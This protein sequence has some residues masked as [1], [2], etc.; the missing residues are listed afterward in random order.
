[1][2]IPTPPRPRVVLL[3]AAYP[4]LCRSQCGEDGRGH[5]AHWFDVGE[6][7]RS[8]PVGAADHRVCVKSCPKS[9]LLDVI[10]GDFDL[11]S[12]NTTT[13]KDSFVCYYKYQ[14]CL[15]EGTC[16]GEL[17][18]E[19]KYETQYADELVDSLAAPI[20]F[21]DISRWCQPVA[22]PTSSV[23]NRCWPDVRHTG[24][25]QALERLVKSTNGT[26]VYGAFDMVSDGFSDLYKAYAVW[27]V[28]GLA[29]PLVASFVWLVVM[30]YLSGVMAWLTVLVVNLV[31]IALTLWCFVKAGFIG[32]D[33]V[34]TIGYDLPDALDT[35]DEKNKE[36]FEYLS[37]TAAVVT[38]LMLLF[39]IIMIPRIRIA[40]ATIKVASQAIGAMPLIIFFPLV[41]FVFM[42][43]LVVYWA[44]ISALIYTAGEITLDDV[45]C[46]DLAFR[47]TAADECFGY[48]TSWDER[49]RYG[50][51][52]HLF[53]LL[54]TAQFIIGVA[55]TS[56][57]GAVASF[58][59]SRGDS[60][61]MP[62]SPV[63]SS[64]RRTCRYHLGSIAIGSFVVA[65]IQT[66]RI[67]LE[68]LDKKTK[69]AQA[70]NAP[71]RFLMCCAKYCLAYL[72]SVMK[73]IN[74]NGYIMIAVKGNNYCSSVSHAAGIIVRNAL[75]MVAVNT[76]G[77]AIPWLGKMLIS[78]GAGVL[79]FFACDLPE[80]SEGDSQV[81][82]PLFPVV[83]TVI[84]AY[85]VADCFFRC[86]SAL[87]LAGGC[88]FAHMSCPVRS[89]S[90]ARSLARSLACAD[91]RWPPR[92]ACTRW[93]WTPSF[94][95]TARIV[96]STTACHSTPRNSFW[97]PLGSARN[98]FASI[99]QRLRTR[100]PTRRNLRHRSLAQRKSSS[101]PVR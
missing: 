15:E 68:Y 88:A 30:R 59:W 52:Y 75:R 94:S 62:S 25:S 17:E 14:Y 29:I 12:L 79:A 77:D 93:R 45:Q 97:R 36:L 2:P 55:L 58:Y 8:G 56:I 84:F 13:I 19:E 39:T 85:F 47:A 23:L 33:A 72:E 65:V 83:A 48:S 73:F 35:A 99:R 51:L 95:R 18:G 3:T 46:A 60:A 71:L 50:F 69:E 63:L 9:G 26:F 98:N 81:S 42:V 5:S 86:A 89:S 11:S 101:L 76:V 74:R 21:S 90:L 28:C 91:L 7:V 22:L 80:Y 49:L 4:L 92:A 57:A 27:T 87:A 53:G 64:F 6:F 20:T 44:L 82:S 37:Y 24:A 38:G 1:M 67:W 16:D 96:T 32:E 70:A 54:W 31:F 78:V 10:S 34:K 40:I 100:L 43:V 41:P 66:V 61:A